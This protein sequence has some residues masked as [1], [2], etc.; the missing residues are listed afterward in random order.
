MIFCV[1][2][3]GGARL[4]MILTLAQKSTPASKRLPPKNGP[5]PCPEC[6]GKDRFR[7][8]PGKGEGGEWWCR[9]CNL[10]GDVLQFLR[11]IE[12]EELP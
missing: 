10:G 8:W 7:V 2:F 6:G 3:D 11:K 5:V 4:E 9:G 12:G 1:R